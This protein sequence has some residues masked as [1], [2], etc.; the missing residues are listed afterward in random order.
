MT[1]LALKSWFYA[2]LI[3]DE[4]RNSFAVGLITL[5]PKYFS[6]IDIH[7]ASSA[8]LGVQESIQL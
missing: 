7:E 6:S 4:G 3:R 8:F 2:Q 1:F 5:Q